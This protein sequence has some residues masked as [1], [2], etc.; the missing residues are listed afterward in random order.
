MPLPTDKQDAM[1]ARFRLWANQE[2]TEVVSDETLDECIRYG[3]DDIYNELRHPQLEHT[4]NFEVTEFNNQEQQYSS[5]KIP[6]DL[7][8]FI[9]LA[10]LDDKGAIAR[11]YDTIPD[12]RTF[13]SPHA[14]QWTSHRYVWRGFDFLVH[15]KLKVGDTL[16]LHYYRRLPKFDSRYAVS[17]ANYRWEFRTDDQPYLEENNGQ[18]DAED[19]P[20]S[21]SPLF[22][23]LWNTENNGEQRRV[24][25]TEQ[26]RD[27]FYDSLLDYEDP[28]DEP[29]YDNRWT[30][31]F[32]GREANN[33][34]RDNN[35]RLVHYAGLYHLAGFLDLDA[36]EARFEKR[37]RELLARLNSEERFRRA[38]GGNVQINI[39][40]GGLI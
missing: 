26:E 12:L 7:I 5:F 2:S 36:L 20:P 19:A 13:L 1:R 23:L 35:E 3:L 27:D 29:T 31:Y 15:P 8:E 38:K 34:L 11:T 17:A 33:W 40:A 16:Q 21:A 9:Y 6:E 25:D 10:G 22:F 37:F 28:G 39:N 30:S 18:Y 14:E 4:V 32:F 24:F